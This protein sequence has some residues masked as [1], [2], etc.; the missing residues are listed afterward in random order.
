MTPTHIVIVNPTV[1]LIAVYQPTVPC[2]RN[3]I[4]NNCTNGG[5]QVSINAGSYNLIDATQVTLIINNGIHSTAPVNSNGYA[6][7]TLNEFDGNTAVRVEAENNFGYRSNVI[8]A[9][10]PAY[11]AAPNPPPPPPPPAPKQPI[12]G[13]GATVNL[14]YGTTYNIADFQSAVAYADGSPPNLATI[15]LWIDNVAITTYTASGNNGPHGDDTFVQW[16]RQ[17]VTAWE[18][19]RGYKLGSQKAFPGG[20][21]FK[22]THGTKGHKFYYTGVKRIITGY[23]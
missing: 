6:T 19:W 5:F 13:N 3:L 21:T 16:N 23:T 17:Y 11:P 22:F 8:T 15:T 18:Q 10:I 2:V 12:Y 9:V 4:T 7:F 1:T 14:V 20:T